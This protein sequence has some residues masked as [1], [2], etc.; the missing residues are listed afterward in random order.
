MGLV[1]LVGLV[2]LSTVNFDLYGLVSRSQPGVPDMNGERLS[3][4]NRLW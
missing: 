1:N 4:L 3:L 2:N